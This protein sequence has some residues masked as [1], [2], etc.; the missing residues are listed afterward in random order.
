MDLITCIF[1]CYLIA[2]LC[3]IFDWW[4]LTMCLI[5]NTTC[6]CSMHRSREGGGGGPGTPLKIQIY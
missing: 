4:H 3:K 6:T 1:C 2:A 5:V